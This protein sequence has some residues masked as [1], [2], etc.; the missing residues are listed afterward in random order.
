VVFLGKTLVFLEEPWEYHVKV[1]SVYE[2][3]ISEHGQGH[4]GPSPAGRFA[5]AGPESGKIRFVFRLGTG[6]RD[7]MLAEPGGVVAPMMQRRIPGLSGRRTMSRRAGS[8]ALPTG[9]QLLV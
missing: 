3:G 6:W 2:T 7:V 9:S 1:I 8:H 5:P 4:Q